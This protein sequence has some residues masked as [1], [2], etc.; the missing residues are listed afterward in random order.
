ML[1]LKRSLLI[2]GSLV[3][4]D[5]TEKGRFLIIMGGLDRHQRQQRPQ[6]ILILASAVWQVFICRMR[7]FLIKIAIVQE[8]II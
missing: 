3:G 1:G 6:R 8:T 7:D 5:P 4:S 2:M